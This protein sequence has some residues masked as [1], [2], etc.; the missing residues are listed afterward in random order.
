MCD[1][2]DSAGTRRGLG[3]NAARTRRELGENSARTR[4]G[5]GG[6][7][8]AQRTRQWDRATG[9]C[10]AAACLTAVP[11]ARRPS[12]RARRSRPAG[13]PRRPRRR[14][15]PTSSRWIDIID[16][17]AIR[18]DR[19]NGSRSGGDV[20]LLDRFPPF[21]PDTRSARLRRAFVR[22][23]ASIAC[24]DSL[25]SIDDATRRRPRATSRPAR[26]APRIARP[27]Q[28][29][30]RIPT[31]ASSCESVPEF[32]PYEPTDACASTTE[33]FAP[34]VRPLAF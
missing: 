8:V 18:D 4:Q 3:K 33:P 6:K 28:N 2:R 21:D 22:R 1:A 11:R 16:T 12:T 32:T 20:D 15:E 5:L 27:D 24:A 23:I 17:R 30:C 13:Q 9:S 26:R 34:S 25:D 19:R 7:R 14:T 31:I 29:L 10:A